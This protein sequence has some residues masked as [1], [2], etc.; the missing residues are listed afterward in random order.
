MTH[1]EHSRKK[2]VQPVGDMISI[3]DFRALAEEAGGR[4]ILLMRHAERPKIQENDP[5]F[6]K[7]LGITEKGKAM[8]MECGRILAGWKDCAFGASPMRRTRETARV[9]AAGMGIENP[10]I[11]DAAPAG[12]P[13]IWMLDAA[14]V[15]SQFESLG[16]AAFT[17]KY[18]HGGEADGFRPM[19]EGTAM[20]SEWLTGTDF[21][22]RMTLIASHDTIIASYLQGL[23]VRNFDSQNWLGYMHSAALIES[24][25]AWRA[26]YCVPDTASYKNTFI[27]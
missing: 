17:D 9:F 24:N 1:K 8:A 18:M 27:Q 4:C 10:A 19:P 11:F 6:G 7:N 21:G 13:G 2:L 22:G 3:Q 20:M 16:S 26:W 15:H 5:T 25:G 12:I 23:G 14:L